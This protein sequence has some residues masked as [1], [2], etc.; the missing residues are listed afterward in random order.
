MKCDFCDQ[1]A[2][3]HELTRKNGVKLERHLCERCARDQGIPVQSNTPIE[4]ILK[5]FVVAAP[6]AQGAAGPARPKSA[7][8]TPVCPSCGLSFTDFKQSGT[9]GCAGCYRAFESQLGVIAERFHEGGCLHVGKTLK[10]GA[11]APPARQAGAAPGSDDRVQ[12]I[13]T[14]RRQLEEAIKGE[15][16]ERAARLRDDLKRLGEGGAGAQAAPGDS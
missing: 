4:E 3:V 2:T 1:E 10:R 8:G 12:R 9:L 14:L 11:P 7:P 5:H 13:Q 15:Q 16:Y 6:P